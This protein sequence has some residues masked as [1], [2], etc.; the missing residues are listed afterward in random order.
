MS[1][2]GISSYSDKGNI[3]LTAG[4]WSWGQHHT[5]FPMEARAKHSALHSP[6]RDNC[7]E[8]K[9]VYKEEN[10]GEEAARVGPGRYNVR[11]KEEL[12]LEAQEEVQLH[13]DNLLKSC[14]QRICFRFRLPRSK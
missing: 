4:F 8:K 12:A 2:K 5:H 6:R 1:N 13:T 9:G 3:T 10:F 11:Y 7:H 14:R